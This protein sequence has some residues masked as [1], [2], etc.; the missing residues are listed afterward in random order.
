MG[1]LDH[2]TNNIIV[3]AVLTDEGRKRLAANNGSFFIES[4]KL[5]DD[6]VDYS[7]ITKY[8]RTVGKEKITKN[9]PIF[10]GLTNN[11][12]EQKYKLFSLSDRNI[13]RLPSL[14]LVGSATSFSVDTR[15]NTS[16]SI[17]VK[18][19]VTG[20]NELFAELTDASFNIEVNDLFLSVSGNTLP[21]I[22]DKRIATY[23]ILDDR[24]TASDLAGAKQVSFTII[25]KNIPTAVFDVYRDPS[26]ANKI[27]TLIKVTGNYS[28]AVLHIPVY[29]TR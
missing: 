14:V 1:F 28:G 25:P 26:D 4:F 17:T 22:T 27:T 6:E 12:A 15:K 20:V 2:S 23:T 13:T 7:I 9:T 10:E 5:A 11:S 16:A 3:D 21:K 24:V 29:I 18:Q 8:G 19:K